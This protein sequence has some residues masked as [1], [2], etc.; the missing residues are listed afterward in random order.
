MK[1][2]LYFS[3][4]IMNAAGSLGFAPDAR[5]GIDFAS[6]GA[7]VTNP[8]SL[9]SRLPAAQPALIEFPGGFLTHSGLP[10]P[11]LPSVLKKH[12]AR[13]NRADIPVIVISGSCNDEEEKHFRQL[14][15]HAYFRKPFNPIQLRE[16]LIQ[17]TG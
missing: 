6:F 5:N 8:I 17:I 1:R 10:N 16:H 12:S 13:W 2:D 3:K 11:G 7:F 4:P 15:A 14:G 9:R